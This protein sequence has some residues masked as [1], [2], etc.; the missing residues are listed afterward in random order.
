MFICN[1]RRIVA[2]IPS[3]GLHICGST[4]PRFH[5]TRFLS[6]RI[7]PSAVGTRGVKPKK[8]WSD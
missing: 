7:A 6:E 1:S 8:L 3:R 4:L 5:Q 2:T